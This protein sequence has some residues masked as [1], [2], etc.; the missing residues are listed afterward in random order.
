[1]ISIIV[2]I[3]IIIIIIIQD[4]VPALPHLR[5]FASPDSKAMLLFTLNYVYCYYYCYYLSII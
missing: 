4:S 5:S 1:M 3:I 2:V